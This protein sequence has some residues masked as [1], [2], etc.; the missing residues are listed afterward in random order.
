MGQW[1]LPGPEHFWLNAKEAA[2]WLGLR[3][4]EFLA[5]SNK[6]PDL[7]RPYKIGKGYKYAATDLAVYAYLRSRGYRPPA[8]PQ[9]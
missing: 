6:Y 5:E 4:G 7:L 8:E 9:Q 2:R 3:D 1:A